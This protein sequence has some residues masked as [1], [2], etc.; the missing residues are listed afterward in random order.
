MFQV[1]NKIAHTVRIPDDIEPIRNYIKLAFDILYLIDVLEGHEWA[2]S[3]IG[4]ELRKEIGW[5][6]PIDQR[7]TIRISGIN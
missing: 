6:D 7:I 3:M 5:S 4:Q 1:R 2:K